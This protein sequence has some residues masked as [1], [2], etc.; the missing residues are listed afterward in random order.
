[1]PRY[2]QNI[3]LKG[4]EIKEFGDITR[5]SLEGVYQKRMP[6][7]YALKFS[8]WQP[9]EST[10]VNGVETSIPVMIWKSSDRDSI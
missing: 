5:K 7:G 6:E 8:N 1:M 4:N 3:G 10:I 2:G 9:M